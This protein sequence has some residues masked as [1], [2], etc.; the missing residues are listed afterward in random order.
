MKLFRT[1]IFLHIVF[2]I[3]LSYL[4]AKINIIIDIDGEIITNH[5]LDKE[6]K[7]LEILNQ[8]LRSLNYEQKKLVAKKSLAEE[9]IKKKVVDNFL[10][11]DL[12][13]LI[14][15]QYLDD[16][17][18][19]LDIKNEVEFKNLLIK[20]QTYS[21]DQVKEKIKIDFKWNRLVY[22][23]YINSI[24]IDKEK[25]IAKI[26]KINSNYTKDFLLSELVF[27]QPKKNL[28]K[29]TIDQIRQS[30]DEI[31]FNNTATIYSNS[32][33]AKV[34]GKLGW[35]NE[36]NLSQEILNEIINTKEGEMTDLIKLGNFY[37]ILKVEKIRTK[38]NEIDKEKEL[39]KMIQ[40]ETNRQ[41]NKFSNIYFKKAKQNINI[42]EK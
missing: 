32:D 22:I 15:N 3:N 10:K 14:I 2:V 29:D 42:N 16:V 41:L 39:E 11:E 37:L 9:K 28:L 12:N 31:G 4:N 33:S 23:K 24:K 19:K 21:I 26:D 36:N 34:G 27:T 1:I 40:I 18:L 20:N 38:Q 5:D 25:F 6:I 8:N 30:I 35:L 17:Y 7:Y 13:E